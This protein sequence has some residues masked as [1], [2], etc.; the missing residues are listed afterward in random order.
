M[1]GHT[2]HGRA[3]PATL[4]DAVRETRSPSHRNARRRI[5]H[6]LSIERHHVLERPGARR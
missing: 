4:A 5:L 3:E 1:G 6:R 2:R